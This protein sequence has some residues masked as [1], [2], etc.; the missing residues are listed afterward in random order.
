V[1]DLLGG[2]N[3]RETTDGSSQ[4][5]C[6]QQDVVWTLQPYSM[7][8]LRKEGFFNASAYLSENF[9]EDQDKSVMAMIMMFVQGWEGEIW[10]S[11][12]WRRYMGVRVSQDKPSNCLR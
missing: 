9:A 5:S 2:A 1:D 8:R 7:C 6:M 10:S 12:K 3:P 11:D 4:C